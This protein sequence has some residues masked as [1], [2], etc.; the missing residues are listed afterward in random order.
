MEH[1]LW[2][3]GDNRI[4]ALSEIRNVSPTKD[5]SIIYFKDGCKE[6]I[7]D[8]E[9]NNLVKAVMLTQK[10]G[11]PQPKRNNNF[12]NRNGVRFERGDRNERPRDWS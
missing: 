5:G 11:Q 2:V 9:T 6:S 10:G 7:G 1:S 12:N 3:I 8:E 4:V